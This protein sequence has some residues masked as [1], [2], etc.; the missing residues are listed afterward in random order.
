MAGMSASDAMT[1][2]MSRRQLSADALGDYRATSAAQLAAFHVDDAAEQQID[3]PVGEIPV[4]E[5]LKFRVFDMALHSWD[6]ARA[7]AADAELPPELI[8][9]VLAIIE[10][11]PPGMGFG[12]SALGVASPTSSP[13]ERL[14]DL[15]GRRAT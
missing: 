2:V 5:F 8:E 3:H 1:E 12:I 14:L 11:G 6:L 4:S 10:S 13:L 15:T 9:T 7:L